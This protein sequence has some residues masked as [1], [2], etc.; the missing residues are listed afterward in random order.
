MLESQ[1]TTVI[2]P[3][4]NEAATLG[5]MLASLI[6]Q[7][8][9]KQIIVVDDGSTD[10]T[11]AELEPFRNE[12]TCP[13]NGGIELIHLET[14]RGKGFAIR[15][16]IP[17]VR[18]LVTVIQ[19]ADLEYDPV[20]IPRLTRLIFEDR[21]DAVYGSRFSG[22]P[23][24]ALFFWHRFANAMITLLSNLLTNLNLSDMETGAKAI[25]T[26][27]LQKMNLKSNRF[28]FEPEVTARL[29]KMQARIFE[30][31]YPYFGRTY[32]E[33][34]KI[35]V[36]DALAAFWHTIRFNLFD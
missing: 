16:A 23:Q 17:R 35:G 27:L 13:A 20:E 21:A 36:G 24:R 12:G 9:E 11:T 32:Q 1:L 2:V 8:F 18:G 5:R 4:Y 34:K 26:S 29:S 19:D 30:I 25:R 33:G 15:Q 6:S 22:S 28:G 10:G 3:V 7:P 31:D 14:N